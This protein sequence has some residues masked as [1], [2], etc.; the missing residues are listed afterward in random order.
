M[1][2]GSQ[3][4]DRRT[5]SDFCRPVPQ[6]SP[7]ADE[8]TRGKIAFFHR[9]GF[10]IG[11]RAR[12]LAAARKRDDAASETGCVERQHEVDHRQARSDDQCIA[13]IFDKVLDGGAGVRGPWI[14][15][16]TLPCRLE[17][18]ETIRLLIADRQYES[19]GLNGATVGEPDRPVPVVSG[20]RHDRAVIDL[21][22]AAGH[23]AIEDFSNIVGEKPAFRETPAVAAFG[24]EMLREVVGLV[25]PGTHS[26]GTHI[27]KM[28]RLFGRISDPLPDPSA[29]IDQDGIDAAPGEMRGE[30]RP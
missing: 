7:E 21:S 25:G 15:D 30:D 29:S 24:F 4:V 11:V 12:D 2:M 27:Q 18:V 16:E 19:T 26:L 9:R 14:V 17:L 28:R 5:P 23:R 20:R 10:E 6:P 8:V 13:V 3:A 1:T 22:M